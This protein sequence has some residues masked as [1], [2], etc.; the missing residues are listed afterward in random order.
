MTS[1][2]KT[3]QPD[4]TPAAEVTSSDQK[5]LDVQAAGAVD[6]AGE[7]TDELEEVTDP[8]AADMAAADE[9]YIMEVVSPIFPGLDE[10]DEESEANPASDEDSPENDADRK[11]VV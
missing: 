10:D 7:K 9:D 1:K 2:N 3:S 5:T 11:S 8:I 4:N 6:T